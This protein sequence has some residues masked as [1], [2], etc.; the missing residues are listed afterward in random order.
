MDIL[1]KFVVVWFGTSILIVSTA[2]Y[3]SSVIRPLC[4]DW[5]R[6]EVVDDEPDSF[7]I[8]N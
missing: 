7:D 8:Y 1:L 2:W 4:P 3:V 5:W 6:R